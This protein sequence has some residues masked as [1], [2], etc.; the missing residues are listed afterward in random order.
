MWSKNIRAAGLEDATVKSSDAGGD[1]RPYTG[2]IGRHF[3]MCILDQ[4]TGEAL[5]KLSA[6]RSGPY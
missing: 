6:Q 5:A 1:G 3:N 4:T 2:A